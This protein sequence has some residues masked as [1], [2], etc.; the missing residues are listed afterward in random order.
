MAASQP[1]ETFTF[2]K[3]LLET[4]SGSLYTPTGDHTTSVQSARRVSQPESSERAYC[5][6]SARGQLQTPSARPPTHEPYLLGNIMPSCT[7]M[8]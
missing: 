1:Y 5:L 2:L 6:C 4:R 8:K 3:V 7:E